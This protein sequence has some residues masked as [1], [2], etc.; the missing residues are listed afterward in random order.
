[1]TTREKVQSLPYPIRLVAF[2][3]CAIIYICHCITHDTV[4]MPEGWDE[5]FKQP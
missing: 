2:F 5:I 4:D 3:I 1:M